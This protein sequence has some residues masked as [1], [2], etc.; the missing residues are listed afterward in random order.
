MTN[1][2]IA[3]R[4]HVEIE[5]DPNW[6]DCQKDQARTK[7][8]ELNHQC[9]LTRDPNYSAATNAAKKRAQGEWTQR[10]YDVRAGV[11]TYKCNE[12]GPSNTNYPSGEA[13]DDFTHPCMEQEMVN[14]RPPTHQDKR[15]RNISNWAA[16][17]RTECIAGGSTQGPM[18]ML[19][20]KV[21]SAFG[22]S[23]KAAV[24]MGPVHSVR[25]VGC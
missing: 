10:F 20:Y 22:G 5:C 23:M 4:V 19:D 25:L 18:R 13:Q 1:L 6:S 11:P 7:A 21:N 3:G 2:Q 14:G 17:H 15:G 24:N 9:P 12:L 8:A 16:D